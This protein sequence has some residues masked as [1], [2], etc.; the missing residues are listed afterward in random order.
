MSQYTFGSVSVTNG[1][2]VVTGT[3]TEFTAN[4]D[5]GD[6]FKV[7]EDDVFYYIASVDSDTQ[8]T[9]TSTYQGAT[10]PNVPY[11]INKDF[12]AN[13]GLY[14]PNKDDKEPSFGLADNFNK[15]DNVVLNQPDVA[16]TNKT[17]I[18]LNGVTPSYNGILTLKSDGLFS[19]GGK[20]TSLVIESYQPNIIFSDISNNSADFKVQADQAKL[21]ISVNTTTNP[22][23][24]TTGFVDRYHFLDSGYFTI[25]GLSPAIQFTD[26]DASNWK[27]VNNGNNLRFLSNLDGTY[28][29]NFVVW[30]TSGGRMKRYDGAN[31]YFSIETAS[32]ASTMFSLIANAEWQF[33]STVAGNF[34]LKRNGVLMATVDGNNVWTLNNGR[35]KQNSPTKYP[36]TLQNGWVNYGNGY[37]N[38][39]YWKNSEGLVTIEGMISGGTIT[40]NTVITQLPVGYRPVSTVMISS[41]GPDNAGE[42]R[43]RIDSVG[44]LK[45]HW[46]ALTN[47]NWLYINVSFYAA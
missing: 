29:E 16:I 25:E 22:N 43:T 38:L 23:D 19:D 3:S 41:I 15:L 39:S 40:P 12:S 14:L 32:T 13:L 33:R 17:C 44:I 18:A 20:D 36:C 8:I 4:V 11:L 37:G 5:P 28:V 1:S 2:A 45:T 46:I 6:T 47:N 24:P 9:L 7:I 34:E 31:I 10:K 27:I 42:Y 21:T 30:G 35:I 26:T